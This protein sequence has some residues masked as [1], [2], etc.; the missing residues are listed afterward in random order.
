MKKGEVKLIDFLAT[1]DKPITAKEIA[2]YLK[3]SERSVRNY[4]RDI[5]ESH[6][7]DIIIV[8]NHKFQLDYNIYQNLIINNKKPDSPEDRVLFLTQKLLEFGSINIYDATEKFY[9]SDSTIE[10][11]ITR[12]R[13]F[14]LEHEIELLRNKNTLSIEGTAKEFK[15]LSS[16]IISRELNNRKLL[17]LDILQSIFKSIDV[18]KIYQIISNTLD[19]SLFYINGYTVNNIVLHIALM[20]EQI[21]N[22]N[23]KSISKRK[24]PNQLEYKL[25]NDILMEVGKCFSVEISD[26]NIS[27]LA[28][29]LMTKIT[30]RNEQ[31]L[32]TYINSEEYTFIKQQLH[33]ISENFL[34]YTIEDD[35]VLKLTIHIRNL[36]ERSKNNTLIN[37][38]LTNNIKKEHAFIYDIAVS[39]ANQL[40]NKF[41]LPITEGEITFLALHLG[42]YFTQ[43]LENQDRIKA[44]LVSTQYYEMQE[45]LAFNIAKKFDQTLLILGTYNTIEEIPKEELEKS[46]MILST[47]EIYLPEKEIIKISP[48]FSNNDQKLI[49]DKIDLIKQRYFLEKNITTIKKFTNDNLFKK[50]F[51]LS[52]NM[53]YLEYLGKEL[54]DMH[55]I[56]THVMNQII[57]RENLSSTAYSNGIAIPH[58]LEMAANKSMISIVVNEQTVLWGKQYVSIILMIVMHPKD[59]NKFRELLDFIFLRFDDD[60][61]IEKLINS[62]TYQEFI[63]I[64]LQF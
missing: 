62:K 24:N 20:L 30:P 59:K 5:N 1:L 19:Q 28:L 45:T 64:L 48:F 11:D 56:D 52:S 12:L 10:K 31:Y 8:K 63:N 9:I 6:Q 39:L 51:Y 49:Q 36:I 18:Q 13:S 54:I 15:S 27:A 29:L 26:E 33:K 47:L 35:L 34:N 22:T 23:I 55:V 32:N 38:P 16:E 41:K 4:V 60:E 14:L 61:V 53:K 7:K 46:S 57:E 21:Q 42:A 25:A 2:S 17:T 3:V 58:P 44:I 50:N 37:N 43:H 40:Q